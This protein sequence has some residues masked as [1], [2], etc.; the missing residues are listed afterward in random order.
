MKRKFRFRSY[1]NKIIEIPYEI[2]NRRN[3]AK[4]FFPNYRARI[5]GRKRRRKVE[6]V[7]TLISFN[8]SHRYQSFLPFKPGRQTATQAAKHV[9]NIISEPLM[10]REISPPTIPG[11]PR[12]FAFYTDSNRARHRFDLMI[13]NPTADINVTADRG[14]YRSRG[15]TQYLET[16]TC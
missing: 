3:R 4:L 14:K 8:P 5:R 9:A 1:R 11:T 2:W 10:F 7:L 6:Q 12:G 16:H 15:N 13:F